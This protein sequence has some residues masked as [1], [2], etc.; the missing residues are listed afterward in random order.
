MIKIAICDDEDIFINKI[1]R[2]LI[3]VMQKNSV[4]SYEIKTFTSGTELIAMGKSISD[5]SIIFLDINM[6]HDISGF[7]I[8][9][10]IRGYDENIFIVFITAFLDYAPKGYRY[11]AVRF[12]L[13]DELSI[14]LPECMEVIMKR[15][16]LKT[17]KL[18][19]DFLEGRKEISADS[20]WYIESRKHKLFINL[21][22]KPDEQLSLYMK[23]D[24]ME[25]ILDKYRFLRIHKSYLVNIG[26]MED[27]LPYQVL[28]GKGKSLPIP[29]E[30]YKH[31]RDRYYEFRS[32]LI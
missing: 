31:V 32:E 15:L 9:E 21:W 22:K 20:I 7:D 3:D 12:I 29:R 17:G 24:E 27:I 6:N 10:K 5:F 18:E 13:K 28:L 25:V 19:F 23:L 14:M 2:I 1:N 11:N 8:A 30:K 16:R 4:S 26:Y